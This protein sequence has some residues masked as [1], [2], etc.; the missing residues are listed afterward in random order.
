MDLLL[1]AGEHVL[2]R[3]VANGT[4]QAEIVVM[5]HVALHQPPRILQPEIAGNPAVVLVH[6]AVAVPPVVVVAGDDVEPPN[7]PPGADLGLLRPAPDEIRD[8]IPHIVR[9]PAPGQSDLLFRRVVLPLPG[10]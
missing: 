6:L 1:T 4:V 2:R 5:F 7:E 9:N 3:D 10:A 8:L